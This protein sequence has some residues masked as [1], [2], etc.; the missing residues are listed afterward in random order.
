V[1][2][3]I[4]P[5]VSDLIFPLDVFWPTLIQIAVAIAHE[6]TAE[7]FFLVIPFYLQ[8]VVVHSANCVNKV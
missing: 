8:S 3:I 1:P 4:A 2:P 5:L 6:V 7:I